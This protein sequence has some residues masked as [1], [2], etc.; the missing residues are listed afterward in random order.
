[1]KRNGNWI[2]KELSLP[3]DVEITDVFISLPLTHAAL[4]ELKGMD[5]VQ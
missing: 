2:L 4:A 3:A 5:N 1:M